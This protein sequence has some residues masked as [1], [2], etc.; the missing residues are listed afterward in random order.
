MPSMPP[1]ESWRPAHS[2]ASMSFECCS[3]RNIQK[4]KHK[5]CYVLNMCR[6]FVLFTHSTPFTPSSWNT[7]P[8]SGVNES[9]EGLKFHEHFVKG[10]ESWK[11]KTCSLIVFGGQGERELCTQDF[12]RVLVQLRATCEISTTNVAT[13]LWTHIPIQWIPGSFSP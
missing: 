6:K 12:T 3:H 1:L 13:R 8:S 10:W 5:T 2:V 9:N 11:Q 4:N 7:F